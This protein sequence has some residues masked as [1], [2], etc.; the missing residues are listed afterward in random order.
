MKALSIRQPWALSI[1]YG[2]KDIE[3]RNWTT[4]HRGLIAI[5]ASSKM[6]REDLNDWKWHVEDHKL[7]GPWC[8]G[9][10]LGDLQRGGIIGVA[11]IT[12]CAVS[13]NSPWFVGEYGFI[14][15]NPRPVPF[16]PM[17]GQL[18]LFD[19]SPEIAEQIGALL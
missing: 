7:R 2:G 15:A 8:E 12:G 5:H 9:K 1:I 13:S 3:N 18:S 14:L 10:K 6:T 19:L 4:R 11:E 16:I 17:K